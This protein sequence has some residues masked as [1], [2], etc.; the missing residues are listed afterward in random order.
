MYKICFSWF[1]PNGREWI[2]RFYRCR[3]S[4]CTVL[5]RKAT[6]L[7][8]KIR[9]FLF[10]IPVILNQRDKLV[11]PPPVDVL[12]SF[13]GKTSTLNCDWMEF[14]HPLVPQRRISHS[15]EGR[16]CFWLL[17]PLQWSE[18]DLKITRC[19]EQKMAAISGKW[20]SGNFFIPTTI[21]HFMFH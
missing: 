19:S 1:D 21:E 8:T 10:S 11:R 5:R 6:K 4:F 12:K 20:L 7:N 18:H 17:S 9:H 3:K 2:Y 14:R 15:I 16:L 13:S